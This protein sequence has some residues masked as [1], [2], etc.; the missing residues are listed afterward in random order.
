MY[1]YWFIKRK[2]NNNLYYLLFLFLFFCTIATFLSGERTAFFL[3]LLYNIYFLFCFS[4][5]KISRLYFLLITI[6]SILFIL[7]I[8]KNSYNRIVVDTLND[9]GVTHLISD[10]KSN[11]DFSSSINKFLKKE[12]RY[13][14]HYHSAIL[15]YKDNKIFGIGPKNFRK[16]CPEDKYIINSLSCANHPHSTWIQILTETGIITFIILVIFFLIVLLNF[17]KY[18]MN[19]FK[20]KE[21]YN[22][23]E[24]IIV[25]GSFFVTL[26][27][28]IPSGNFFNNWLSIVYFFP[29]GFYLILNEK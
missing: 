25:L 24:K 12:N 26:W 4:R 21:N 19:N 7:S 15:M 27:P 17:F 6:F 11:N 20:K 14:S 13:L 9:T 2:E 28:V 1:L 8:N 3:I 10:L 22:L 18:F 23:D 16:L 5:L 29:L